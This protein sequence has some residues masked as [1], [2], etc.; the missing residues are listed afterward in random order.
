L[1]RLAIGLAMERFQRA[2]GSL[3]KVVAI[4]MSLYHLWAATF[5][6]PE[7]M[8]HRSIH[9][10]FT[11]GLIF[12]VSISGRKSNQSIGLI[13]D[14]LLLAGSILAMGHIF[15]NYDYVV[16]RYPYVQSLSGW[17][18]WLGILVTLL[19]LEASRRA[20]GPA[21][22]LTAV[23]FLLYG[24]FGQHLPG[25]LRHTGFSLETLV[26]QLYLTTE[27][28]FGIPLGVSAT[29]V[30]LFVIYGS[31][32]EES[33]TGE[34]FTQFAV[35][36]VGGTRG[37]P[38]KIS[39]VSSSLFGTISGSAVANVMVD[40]WLTIPLMKRAGFR[41]D[42]AAAVEATASTGGQIMPPVMGAAAFVIA[43]FTGIS[44]IDICKHALVPALLYYLALF[45]AIHFEASR[46]GL[47]GIPREERPSLKAVILE[48]GHLFVPILVIVYFMIGGYTPM[49]ACLYAIAS[50]LPMSFLRKE[51]RMDLKKILRALEGGAR[52]ML[53]VAAACACAGI[54]VGIINLTGLGLKFTGLML[55]VAGGSLAPALLLTMLTGIIL[56]MGLPTTAAY[57]VQ[58]A[59]LIPG[60]IKLGVPVI[61][62]HLFV[63]YFAIISAITPPVAMAVYA[64]AGIGGSNVWKTGIQA[65]RI[66]ATGFVVPFMFV[67]GPSLLLIGSWWEVATT[68]LSASLGV[69]LLS[70]GLMGWFMGETRR[71]Q[72]VVLVA[73]AILLIKPGLVTDLM[74]VGLV[75]LVGL[76]QRLAP[77]SRMQT[78]SR[79]ASGQGS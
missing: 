67:Y 26:D 52:N 53:A 8:M 32:L 39:C 76:W 55:D 61:A 78:T 28:I 38:G 70:G 27:G 68:I 51:S 45:M 3:L 13:T 15:L 50:V 34:A 77:V 10:T 44:Y 18:F 79:S 14:I 36:L 75:V 24:L 40:G 1:P 65:V 58:A 59:L 37:G 64:A 63:F 31:F 35:S 5:G 9:L 30:I 41:P 11:F 69:I 48:K 60:L 46:S 25:I 17:D 42:F 4:S 22:P 6:S 57:I 49:L 20:I 72:Q 47:M 12:L 29:Y 43:E 56:G 33:G 74:G 2:V 16:T 21:L 62:A 66:G 71:W 73:A 7:A 19:L 54:V 23:A